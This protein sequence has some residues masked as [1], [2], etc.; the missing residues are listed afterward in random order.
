MKN[1]A[2]LLILLSASFLFTPLAEAG[3]KLNTREYRPLS[4]KMVRI[5][6]SGAVTPS[7]KGAAKRREGWARFDQKEWEKSMDNFLSALEFDPTDDSAAEGLTMAVYRSG[8]RISAANLAEEFSEVMPW[9][10][11]MVAETVLADVK[12]ELEKG[13]LTAAETLMGN[14][15]YGAGAYDGVRSLVEG[16]SSEAAAEA[17]TAVAEVSK[18]S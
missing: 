16:A 13:G 15:P 9:I 3:P 7:S 12:A 4:A 11:G 1:S 5:N 14:L 6:V 18:K 8:D 2:H 17:K 10:R